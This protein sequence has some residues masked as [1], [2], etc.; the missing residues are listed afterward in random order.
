MIIRGHFGTIFNHANGK[1]IL[2]NDRSPESFILVEYSPE[3]IKVNYPKQK[4]K[5]TLR[6]KKIK[7][8]SKDIKENEYI[9][10]DNSIYEKLFRHRNEFIE[11]TNKQ[12]LIDLLKKGFAKKTLYHY[13][14]ENRF[15]DESYNDLQKERASK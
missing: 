9:K 14:G 1:Y 4:W 13:L 15:I 8:I 12:L 3:N 5:V 2:S 11:K 7:S 6:G 10:R